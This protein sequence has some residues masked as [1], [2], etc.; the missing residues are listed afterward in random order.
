MAE[1]PSED[2]MK[3]RPPKDI[4]PT[5]KQKLIL[6][7]IKKF[8]YDNLPQNTKLHKIRLFGSLAKG[9][10]GKYKGKWKGREFSDIDVLFIV[11]D[12]FKPPKKWKIHFKPKDGPMRVY[13][14]ATIPVATEDETVFV[15]VQY[16]ILPKTYA[17]E[18]E[19][20]AKAEQWGIPL[21]S[22]F[23]KH[24]FIKL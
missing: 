14:I 24:R 1:K 11:D 5:K 12:N 7:Q 10:F 6:S 16:I 4:F 22:F 19:T 23:S 21:K 3:E 9:T 18:P 8:I 15:E 17:T 20:I 13:D 2:Y